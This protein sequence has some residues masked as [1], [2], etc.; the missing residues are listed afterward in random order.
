MSL[1]KSI[2]KRLN[3]TAQI[4]TT[5]QGNV[6]LSRILG[7]GLFS[8]QEA[9][10]HPEWLTIPP[11]EESKETEEY[12]IGNF[13]FRSRRPF[14]P[15]RLW[16]MLNSEESI[17]AGVLR[18]KGFAWFAT[19][20]DYAYQWSQAGVSIQLNPAGIWWDAASD[21]YCPDE[22]HERTQLLSQFDGKYGDRRQEL[23][24][25]GIDLDQEL[26][27]ERL[28]QCLLTDLEYAT[29]TELWAQLPDPLPA[30]KVEEDNSE[31]IASNDF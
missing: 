27:E 26:I 22:P 15:E 18:S 20:H 30:I 14:H 16:N 9:E 11:G 23:V 29:G 13:V 19:R 24:F 21:E 31:E 6:P 25:I 28:Q 2:L 12:N 8:L 17:L 3:P 4:L 1:L 5:E 10:Q 7:T